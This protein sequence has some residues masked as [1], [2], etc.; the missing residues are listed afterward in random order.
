MELLVKPDLDS[1]VLLQ[2]TEKEVDGRKKNTA[3][4]ATTSAGHVENRGL[5]WFG[6]LVV[7]W[8]TSLMAM[9]EAELSRNQVVDGL[10]CWSARL[11][12][13]CSQSR[14]LT[15]GRDFNEFPPGRIACLSLACGAHVFTSTGEL[16]RWP[17][18]LHTCG[19]TASCHNFLAFTLKRLSSHRFF[20]PPACPTYG[21]ASAFIDPPARRR[22]LHSWSV[23]RQPDVLRLLAGCFSFWTEEQIVAGNLQ[24]PGILSPRRHPTV[25]LSPSFLRPLSSFIYPVRISAPRLSNNIT[26]NLS[27]RRKTDN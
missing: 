15:A 24:L 27:S 8:D 2:K 9:L 26:C 10:R 11:G 21:G 17:V 5:L 20:T 19:P 4:A 14:S 13:R 23:V 1:R 18:R 22:L 16:L 7:V 12:F 25:P 6:R 3:V